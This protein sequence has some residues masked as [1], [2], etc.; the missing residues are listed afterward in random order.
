MQRITYVTCPSLGSKQM[1]QCL[2]N[3][4]TPCGLLC[5]PINFNPGN[6]FVA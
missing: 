6:W 1:Q 3:P 5:G 2:P 4:R